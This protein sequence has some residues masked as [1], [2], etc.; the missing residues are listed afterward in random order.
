MKKI[1]I[2]KIFVVLKLS[3]FYFEIS[4]FS[5]PSCCISFILYLLQLVCG[6][7]SIAQS[8]EAHL[9]FIESRGLNFDKIKLWQIYIKDKLQ[10]L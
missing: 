1:F 9:E 8:Y 6:I 2:Q 7:Q 4:S 3:D 5:A 10:I